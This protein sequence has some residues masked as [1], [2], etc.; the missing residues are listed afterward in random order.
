MQ[1]VLQ[2]GL[3]AMFVYTDDVQAAVLRSKSQLHLFG[4]D[5][6]GHLFGALPCHQSSHVEQTFRED[7]DRAWGRSDNGLANQ[8]S[9]LSAAPH[10]L[11][12][13]PRP[14]SDVD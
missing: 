6:D 3:N 4:G 1:E 9:L 2:V 5:T 10:C 14:A 8:R 12:H 7:A 11:R 13:H